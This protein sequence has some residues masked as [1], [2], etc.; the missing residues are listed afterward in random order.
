[1]IK[2]MTGYGTAGVNTNKIKGVVE[3][4]TQNHRYF[5][6]VFYLPLG[7]SSLENKIK[8]AINAKIKRGRVT[9]SFKITERSTQAIDLNKAAVK[10]YLSY[11]KQLKKEFSLTSELSVADLIKLPGVVEA[12]DTLVT[13][14]QVATSLE[15]GLD[16]ALKSLITMRA[17]EGKSLAKDINVIL[18][19]MLRQVRIIQM[20]S[21]ALLKKNKKL[22]NMDEFLSYQKGIDISEELTRLKHYIEEFKLLLKSTVSVGK[23]LDFVAQE[24]QRETNTIGSKVQ[25]RIISN[26]VITIKSK[27]EKLREQAQNIE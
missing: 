9:F 24:M 19:G 16:T 23:K 10:K 21:K 15:K 3:I 2:G 7:F 22:M 11:A 27:I 4:K 12:K 6:T 1:M 14:P 26:A 17:R 5:D 8:N 13:P 25:D 20:R 18:Q